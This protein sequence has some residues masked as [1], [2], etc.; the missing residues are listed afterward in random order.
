MKKYMLLVILLLT[1]C[2]D[3][4]EVV[5]VPQPSDKEPYEEYQKVVNLY[6][7]NESYSMFMGD[8]FEYL[9]EE[10]NWDAKVMYA[11][12]DKSGGNIRANNAYVEMRN[13]DGESTCDFYYQNQRLYLE[14][15]TDLYELEYTQDRLDYSDLFLS[16]DKNQILEI[17]YGELDEGRGQFDIKVDPAQLD[18]KR[19]FRDEFFEGKKVLKTETYNVLIQVNEVGDIITMG[20][21]VDI[22]VEDEG[23][24]KNVKWGKSITYSDIGG[25]MI[26]QVEPPLGYK[27]I[28]I[29]EV[30]KCMQY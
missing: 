29:N 10:S 21:N 2:N 22:V 23:E 9:A 1:G 13:S 3:Y 8:S 17:K 11:D 14:D 15:G 30:P 12:V 28:T 19:I 25:I 27:K 7:D 26:N 20:S 4:G 5:N 16:F 18:I 6:N 24:S